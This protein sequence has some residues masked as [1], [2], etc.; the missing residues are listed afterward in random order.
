MLPFIAAI[1]LEVSTQAL[2]EGQA[3]RDEVGRFMRLRGFSL[4]HEVVI[5]I[6]G[7][8]LYVNRRLARNWPY[9]ATKR[10]EGLARRARNW[11]GRWSSRASAHTKNR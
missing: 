11:A 5:G 8:Q 2:Y 6:E 3:L 9:L 7:D 10:M 4:A 1:W